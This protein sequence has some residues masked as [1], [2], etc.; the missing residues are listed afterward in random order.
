M[1]AA[2]PWLL[3]DV[4]FIVL[5]IVVMI[6]APEIAEMLARRDAHSPLARLWPRKPSPAAYRFSMLLC[7]VLILYFAGRPFLAFVV[8]W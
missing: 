5:A 8:G 2:V 4:L 3:L 6:K 1:V 7:A